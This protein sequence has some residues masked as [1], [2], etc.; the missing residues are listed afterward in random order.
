[1]GQQTSCEL[2][3][4]KGR[5]LEQG[6][7]C[8]SFAAIV[9]IVILF[10]L[11]LFSQYRTSISSSRGEYNLKSASNS[12]LKILQSSITPLQLDSQ[13]KRHTFFSGNFLKKTERIS[14][15]ISIFLSIYLSIQ[16]SNQRILPLLQ[17]NYYRITHLSKLFRVKC[18]LFFLIL[19]F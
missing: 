2:N 16:P 17:K 1:M 7:I 15:Y 3:I 9:T 14:I 8:G 11:I 4:S 12:Y 13:F 18:P 10:Y 6:T 5:I 19:K